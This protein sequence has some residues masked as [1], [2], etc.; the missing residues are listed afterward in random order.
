MHKMPGLFASHLKWMES[1]NF[2]RIAFVIERN[3]NFSS[4]V[5]A[6]STRNDEIF[7]KNS[8]A[9]FSFQSQFVFISLPLLSIISVGFR[10]KSRYFF[11]SIS[12]EAVFVM[13]NRDSTT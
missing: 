9:F 7:V 5:E 3:C 1:W 10:Y 4:G 11:C 6:I 12:F 2:P 8:I 13:L